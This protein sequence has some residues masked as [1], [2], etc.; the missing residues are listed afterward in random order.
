MYRVII[1]PS[2][3]VAVAF[4][5]SLQIGTTIAQTIPPSLLQ[6]GT[7]AAIKERKIAAFP[8][9]R[10]GPSTHEAPRVHHAYRRRA[11]ATGSPKCGSATEPSSKALIDGFRTLGYD[12]LTSVDRPLCRSRP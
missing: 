5:W 1:L 11:G 8:L 3:V 9:A 2:F 10:R 12:A 6:G 4:T 7:D